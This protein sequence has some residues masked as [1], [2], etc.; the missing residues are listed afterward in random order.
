MIKSGDLC[1]RCGK[2]L[3]ITKVT[4]EY[5]GN[6]MVTTTQMECSD[7]L[8]RKGLKLQLAKEKA[9]REIFKEKYD[10]V[11]MKHN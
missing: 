8:C 11:K 3:I 7:S 9:A 6:S 1:I 4:K 2:D 5:V 10:A